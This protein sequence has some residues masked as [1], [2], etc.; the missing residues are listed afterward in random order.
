MQVDLIVGNDKI[1]HDNKDNPIIASSYSY[2]G[3]VIQ[4]M[5]YIDY[6]FD[7]IK[8]DNDVDI[9]LIIIK[10]LLQLGCQ[11]YL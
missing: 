5:A 1:A 2:H 7:V 3:F 9:F 10:I 4:E 11:K 6:K 8:Y